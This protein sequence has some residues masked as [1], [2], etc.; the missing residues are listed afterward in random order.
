MR[1]RNA[2][3]KSKTPTP[4]R[5]SPTPNYASS[6]SSIPVDGYTLG[7]DPWGNITGTPASSVVGS[8]GSR[9]PGSENASNPISTRRLID[10]FYT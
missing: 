7:S 1:D 2:P 6:S 8:V 3:K 5:T 9:S 4:S 10:L